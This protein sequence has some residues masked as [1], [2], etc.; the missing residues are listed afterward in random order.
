MPVTKI[1]LLNLP[2]GR[3]IQRDYGCPHE[4]K[5]AYSWPPVDLLL[6]GGAVRDTA[7]LSYLD[8]LAGRFSWAECLG[9]IGALRPDI[10][11]TIISSLSLESDLRHLGELKR[12]V[13]A[14]RVWASG[15]VVFFTDRQFA[16]IDVLVRD[17]TNGEAIR[18]L[19]AGGAGQGAVEPGGGTAFQAGLPPHE[20]ITGYGYAMPYSR[21]RNITSVLTN[22]GCPF[23]CTFCNSNGLPFRKRPVEEI[24]RELQYIQGLGIREVVFRDF[25]FT[26]SDTAELCERIEA[27]NI[28]L[29]WSCWTRVDTVDRELLRKMK[30]AGC[31]LISYGIESGDDAILAETGKALTMAQIKEAVSLTREAG[32]EVLVSIILGF[33]GDDVR[34]T[35]STLQ[36]LDP[37]YVA[38]N[39][40]EPRVGSRMAAARPAPAADGAGRATPAVTAN[41][42]ALRAAVE[43]GFYLRPRKLARY[44]LL[45]LRSRQRLAIFL[46]NAAGLFRKWRRSR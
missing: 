15:D 33:P 38:V 36:R 13:P 35:I 34:R 5:A 31:Y 17:L 26:L 16:A 44:L 28:R 32:L 7:A 27:N 30:A 39:L 3:L 9:R 10:V 2:F 20:L 14:V 6:F 11:F 18:R 24:V 29:A 42:P 45:A 22:Y 23:H 12:V 1:V 41:L 43:K 19:V 37:D 46:R 4:I 40:L 21:Y 8:C 25:T